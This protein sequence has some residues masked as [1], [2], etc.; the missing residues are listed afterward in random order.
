VPS[1]S[2]SVALISF[3]NIGAPFKRRIIH[4][5]GEPEPVEPRTWNLEPGTWRTL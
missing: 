5:A 2:I 4:P 3:R 1:I